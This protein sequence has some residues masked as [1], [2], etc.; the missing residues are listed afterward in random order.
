MF[1]LIICYG[2]A[3]RPTLEGVGYCTCRARYLLG[4]VGR[5]LRVGAAKPTA[6]RTTPMTR[7][8]KDMT[9]RHR[10]AVSSVA[11]RGGTVCSDDR[12]TRP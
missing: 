7:K 1:L 2:I 12:P 9:N 10:L 3:H 8:T 4:G 5:R 6:V 11:Q